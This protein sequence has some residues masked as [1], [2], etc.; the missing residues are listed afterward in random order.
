MPANSKPSALSLILQECLSHL[1][2]VNKPLF[3]SSDFELNCA[4]AANRI[5]DFCRYS[6][7]N[8]RVGDRCHASNSKSSGDRRDRR[9]DMLDV[10]L[11]SVI[12][13]LSDGVAVSVRPHRL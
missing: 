5:A 4:G 12:F 6:F 3:T 8:K 10:Y 9:G 11:R 1:L 13:Q 7:P 2:R